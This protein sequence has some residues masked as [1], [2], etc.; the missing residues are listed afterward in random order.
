MYQ[1][2][3]NFQSLKKTHSDRK[4]ARQNSYAITVEKTQNVIQYQQQ[5]ERRSK[6]NREST[7]HTAMKIS[8]LDKDK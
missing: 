8:N 7:N 6:R 2:S 4:K 1:K 3:V 5:R